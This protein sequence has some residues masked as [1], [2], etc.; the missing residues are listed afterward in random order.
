M[1]VFYTFME[2]PLGGNDGA[3]VQIAMTKLRRGGV[4]PKRKLCF[5][6]SLEDAYPMIEQTA[7]WLNYLSEVEIV[8]G[9]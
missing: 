2:A 4:F 6:C 9:K 3:W 8:R 1:I 5:V 7:E